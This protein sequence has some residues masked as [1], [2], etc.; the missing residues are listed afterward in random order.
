MVMRARFLLAVVAVLLCF[1]TS[2]RVGASTPATAPSP[3]LEQIDQAI[4]QRWSAFVTWQ[5]NYRAANGVYFQGLHSHR[6]S[7]PD[8]NTTATPTGLDDRPTDRPHALRDFW[9]GNMP[10][11]TAFA[12][13]INVYSGPQGDG[14]SVTVETTDNGVRMR[15]V[16][17][18]GPEVWREVAWEAVR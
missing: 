17:N 11:R 7:A 1:G 4:A 6:G 5:E 14:W 9:N 12:L 3:T 2:A 10:N 16:L 8:S 13:I 18:Y 15:R